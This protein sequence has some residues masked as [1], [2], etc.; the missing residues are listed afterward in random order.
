MTGRLAALVWL[1]GALYAQT[2]PS[3]DEHRIEIML[4]R[5]DG[6]AWRAIDP[7]LVLERSDRVRFRFRTNF[8]GYLYVL[9][10]STSGRYE[11][12]FPREETGQDNRVQA[13]REY[14]VP[15]TS[16]V[17]RITGPAGHELVY[18]LVSPVP[19][20]EGRS[21]HPS[22][23]TT[24]KQPRPALVPRCDDT[25]LRAR[26]DCIDNGAGLR[27]VP[28]DGPVP[29]NLAGA[30]SQTPEDLLVLRQKDTSVVSSPGPLSGPVIYEFRLAH[31]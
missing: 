4:D 28:R 16:S 18:W 27:L 1:A 12:L 19:L 29:Q 23:P 10:Q 31:R 8:N 25:I 5:L 14:Q 30:A 20:G 17:F 9:N 11:Q 2:G 15:A 13:G 7:G 24:T 3:A 6:D 26:G 21:W 22:P